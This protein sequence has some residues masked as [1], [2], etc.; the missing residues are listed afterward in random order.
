MF[1]RRHGEHRLFAQ[2][3]V[4]NQSVVIPLDN[5][6]IDRFTERKRPII[7][8]ADLIDMRPAHHAQIMDNIAAADNQHTLFAQGG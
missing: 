5:R 8:R 3:F 6:L 4:M 1:R 7:T 2:P